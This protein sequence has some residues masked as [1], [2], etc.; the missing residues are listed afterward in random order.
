VLMFTCATIK[1]YFHPIRYQAQEL[2]AWAMGVCSSARI[3]QVKLKLLSRKFLELD[4]V[5]HVPNIRQ[6]LISISLLGRLGYNVDFNS[7]KVVIS[8]HG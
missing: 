3:R 5:Y 1:P 7:N 6:I 4:V 8:R 2:R